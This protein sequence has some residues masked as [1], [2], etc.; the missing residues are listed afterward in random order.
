MPPEA[1]PFRQPLAAGD[2]TFTFQAPQTWRSVRPDAPAVEPPDLA[3]E[4]WRVLVSQNKPIQRKTPTWQ[5]LPA[6]DTVE[7]QMPEQSGFRCLVAPLVVRSEANTF[8]TA[9]KAWVMTRNVLCS[10]DGFRTW[11]ETGL[12][13]ELAAD[14]GRRIG[15]EAGLLLRERVAGEA[16]PREMFVLLRS[17]REQREASLG[18]PRILENRQVDVD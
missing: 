2:P 9:F 11:N 14:G 5:P 17:D 12:Q 6:A 13:V 10:S 16:A 7:L 4:T 1:A 15:P 8:G 18:P 3:E